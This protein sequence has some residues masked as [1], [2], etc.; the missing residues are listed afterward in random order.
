MSSVSMHGERRSADQSRVVGKGG[1]GHE[2]RVQVL[3]G[4]QKVHR[5]DGLIIPMRCLKLF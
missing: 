2:P 4:R 3:R 1:K 5:N